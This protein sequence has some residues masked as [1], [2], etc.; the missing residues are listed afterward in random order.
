MIGRLSSCLFCL[1]LLSCATAKTEHK[2]EDSTVV[3]N[4]PIILEG[5]YQGENIY[6]QNPYSEGAFC[7]TKI[8]VNNVEAMD[9][10][11][12]QVSAIEIKLDSLIQR[13]GDTVII[14]ISHR[15][16]CYPKVLKTGN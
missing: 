5:T 15:N 10:A 13:N 1:I 12:L 8:L 3:S 4:N 14:E 11:H 16:N 2:G 6:V 7:V 9:S